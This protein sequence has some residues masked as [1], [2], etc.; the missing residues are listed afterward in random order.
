MIKLDYPCVHVQT[1]A[2]GA[3]QP[4]LLG[5][6]GDGKMGPKIPDG[7]VTGTGKPISGEVHGRE[8]VREGMSLS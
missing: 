7:R 8:A 4:W 2:G 3:Q 5:G 6:M 1:H